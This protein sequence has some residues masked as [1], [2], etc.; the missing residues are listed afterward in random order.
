MEKDFQRI[1]VVSVTGLQSVAEGAVRAITKSCREMPGTKAM[2]ISPERP[3]GTPEWIRHVPIQPFG[4]TEYSLFILYV[5]GHFIETE[6]ALIVQDDGWVLSGRN[7]RSEFLDYDMIGAPVHLAG[8]REASGI[9]FYRGFQWESLIGKPN[10]RV[11]IVYNGGFSLRS[12][13]LMSAPRRLGLPF[14]IPPLS[15]IVGPPWKM[16]WD[17][18]LTLEDVQLCTAMRADLENDGLHFAPLALAAHFAVEHLGELLHKNADLGQVFGHHSKYRKLTSLDP[19][20][21]RYVV[22]RKRAD[23]IHGEDRILRL[24]ESHGMTIEWPADKDAEGDEKA[25]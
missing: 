22:G 21:A 8:V 10:T 12:K 19:Y 20:V 2:L 18:D 17:T 13:R 5:L 16:Q 3:E 23:A 4:Y 6:F 14:V 15:K 7:W 24:L 11:D 25:L 1:T 9:T